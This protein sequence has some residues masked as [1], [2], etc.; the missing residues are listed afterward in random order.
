MLLFFRRDPLLAVDGGELGLL[1]EPPLRPPHL[2]LHHSPLVEVILVEQLLHLCIPFGKLQSLVDLSQ[3]DTVEFLQVLAIAVERPQVDDAEAGPVEFPVIQP[4]LEVRTTVLAAP[5]G[6]GQRQAHLRDLLHDETQ[7]E[8]RIVIYTA[9][10]FTEILPE[11]ARGGDMELL[12]VVT[13]KQLGNI[14][15]PLVLREDAEIE[16]RSLGHLDDLLEVAV[17]IL[18]SLTCP[19]TCKMKFPN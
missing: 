8:D 16:P 14:F 9:E 18:L 2:E 3:L 6:L 12:H 7:T 1:G 4:A 19:V 10:T 5:T 13:G 17:D 15:D 11:G